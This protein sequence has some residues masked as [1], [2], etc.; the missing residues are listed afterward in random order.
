MSAAAAAAAAA[1]PRNGGDS[2]SEKVSYAAYYKAYSESG[3][4]MTYTDSLRELVDNSVQYALDGNT[5][6]GENPE[7]RIIISLKGRPAEHTVAVGDN[8]RGMNEEQLKDFLQC[9]AHTA[10]FPIAPRLLS[11]AAAGSRAAPPETECVCACLPSEQVLQD[12]EGP[13]V[14]NGRLGYICR[15]NPG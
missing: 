15:A 7:I 9:V 11:P 1:S 4:D 3:T 6:P 8:G 10:L 2:K 13:R 14:R 5:Q 12:A